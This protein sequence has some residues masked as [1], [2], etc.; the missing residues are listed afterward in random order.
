MCLSIATLEDELVE[1]SETIV[2]AA[3]GVRGIAV[4]GSPATLEVNSRECEPTFHNN[5]ILLN[6]NITMPV[7]STT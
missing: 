6:V 3:T 5:I 4:S 2:I 7:V 1:D